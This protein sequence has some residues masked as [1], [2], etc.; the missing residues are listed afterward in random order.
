MTDDLHDM[1]IGAPQE[2]E[3][4]D[5]FLEAIGEGGE[6]GEGKWGRV[7]EERRRLRVAA[8]EL[9]KVELGY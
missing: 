8:P 6:G 2:F 9:R 1:R 3:N 5:A 4:A 7:E